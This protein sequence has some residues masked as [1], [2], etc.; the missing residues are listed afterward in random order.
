MVE[1]CMRDAF[2]ARSSE[3]GALRTF[4]EVSESEPARSG[5]NAA[6]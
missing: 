4:Y 5:W 3:V 6:P 1:S 2:S